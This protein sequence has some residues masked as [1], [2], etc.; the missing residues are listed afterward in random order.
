MIKSLTQAVHHL[1]AVLGVVGSLAVVAL[2][3]CISA[4]VTY[5]WVAGGSVPGLLEIS[6]FLVAIAVFL[7]LAE[8]QRRSGH[9]RV[10]L[11]TD[12]MSDRL[13]RATRL[14]GLAL[15]AVVLGVTMI[16]SWDRLASSYAAGESRWG[17]L[18]IPTWPGRL[19]VAIGLTVLLAEVFLSIG[20]LARRT[21]RSADSQP[22]LIG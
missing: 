13:A 22:P 7:G 18:N 5:R 2:M 20:A 8:A 12:R 3:L 21:S 15:S 9:I 10:H 17:L 1:S 19:A 4:D 14:F 6:E 11:V 16:G